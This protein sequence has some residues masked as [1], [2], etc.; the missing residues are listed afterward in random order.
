MGG[1]DTDRRPLSVVRCRLPV[2]GRPFPVSRFP[3]PVARRPSPVA[4][5]PLS[6]ARFL[7]PSDPAGRLLFI[8]PPLW[9]KCLGERSEP[10]RWGGAAQNHA[11]CP[12]SVVG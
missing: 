4:G 2:A 9:G 7:P 3:S 5:C 1:L 10:R 12:L 6:V 11:R 8:L